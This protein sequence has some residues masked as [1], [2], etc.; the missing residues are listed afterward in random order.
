MDEKLQEFL[1]DS[2]SVVADVIHD[3]NNLNLGIAKEKLLALLKK[4][5]ELS[6]S[7]EGRR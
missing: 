1:N 6:E 5:V 7:I 3:L 2:S 4:G